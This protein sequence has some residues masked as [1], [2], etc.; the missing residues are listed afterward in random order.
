MGRC[1]NRRTQQAAAELRNTPSRARFSS[2]PPRRNNK[3]RGGKG[4]DRGRGGR[5]GDAVKAAVVEKLSKRV[6]QKQSKTAAPVI[7]TRRYRHPLANVDIT[8]LD[9]LVLPEESLQEVMKLLSDLNVK[10]VETATAASL[11][12]IGNQQQKPSNDTANTNNLNGN[13]PVFEPAT[14]VE[15]VNNIEYAH[16][17]GEPAITFNMD[18]DDDDDDDYGEDGNYDGQGGKQLTRSNFGAYEEQEEDYNE[19]EEDLVQVGYVPSRVTDAGSDLA[20]I[21]EDGMD[22]DADHRDGDEPTASLSVLDSLNQAQEKFRDNP[23]YLHLTSRLSFKADTAL[24]ACQAIEDMVSSEN[25]DNDNETNNAEMS[26]ANNS[27]QQQKHQAEK[28]A[29]AMDWLC[30]HCEEKELTAGFKMNPAMTSS[31]ILMGTGRTTA[32]AHPSI[33]LAKK[34]TEDRDWTKSILI[35]EKAVKFLPL[36]FQHSE[37]YDA[38]KEYTIERLEQESSKTK[39]AMEDD[40]ALRLLLATLEREVLEEDQGREII[41]I[42]KA[43]TESDLE[44]ATTEREAEE[45]ALEAIYADEFQIIKNNND[46]NDRTST[47]TAGLYRYNLI[48]TPSEPLKEPARSEKCSLHVFVRP[49]YPVL[50]PPLMF[51]SNPTLPPSLLRRVNMELVRQ[52]HQSL[53]APA[54]FEI[55]NFLST[56]LLSL[57]ETFMKEQNF[58]EM[59]AEQLRLR[60]EAGHVLDDEVEMG[61]EGGTMGRRQ[62][63]KMRAAAKA[64]DRPD[65]A[66]QVEAE[67]RERQSARIDR[68]KEEG[69]TQNIRQSRAERAIEQREKERQDEE[70]KAVGRAAMNAAFI[71]GASVEEAREASEK[72]QMEYKHEHGLIEKA[73]PIATNTVPSTVSDIIDTANSQTGAS[74]A[75]GEEKDEEMGNEVPTATPTT[76]AFMERLREMYEA[77]AKEKAEGGKT[78][79]QRPQKGKKPEQEL[80]AYHLNPA[81]EEVEDEK[82]GEEPD[83]NIR[84]PRPVAVPVGELKRVM[85][86]VIATQKDQPWLIA[87]EARA[88]EAGVE[89]DSQDEPKMTE[90]CLEISR[91]LKDESERKYKSAMVWRKKNEG[92]KGKDA[93]RGQKGS[94]TPQGFS[95]MLSQRGT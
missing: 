38:F 33:S 14:A 78:S 91:S 39:S 83:E 21:T 1:N 76:A 26:N 64:F 89:L 41:P 79:A 27:K 69:K 68:A 4:H 80:E 37:T 94:F 12:N 70:I 7:V 28:M 90:K 77:A 11:G 88:P 75:L 71:G 18:D 74:E 95:K 15:K 50:E 55:V 30:L 46:E 52:V 19:E 2:G 34:L 60:R 58:K 47:A 16:E 23:V 9:E 22:V 13:A 65:V 49:G 66:Q 10:V 8:K 45:E 48:V 31:I 62:R 63:A 43:Y 92:K 36:G 5:G 6:E 82:E 87:S 25:D 54:V 59:E 24:R 17:Q 53:G 85:E 72:A 56:E 93:P 51:F 35:Q 42:A 32:I 40:E 3:G 20:D 67:R 86:D 84:F 61:E 81:Q 57:Q 29:F 44:D 73:P